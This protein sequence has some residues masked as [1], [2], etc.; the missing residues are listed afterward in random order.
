MLRLS[1]LLAEGLGLVDAARSTS[2]ERQEAKEAAERAMA[3]VPT[4]AP[5][6]RFD[7][8]I[9]RATA[10]IAERVNARCD[11]E[12][13]TKRAE[14]LANAHLPHIDDYVIAEYD[15]LNLYEQWEAIR[16]LKAEIRPELIEELKR[17]D[18]TVDEIKEWIEQTVGSVTRKQGFR[19]G[20]DAASRYES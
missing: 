11:R 20:L 19:T 5:R 15:H 4:G 3:E 16:E 9:E 2:A 17:N 14:S 12:K 7:A 8:A 1:S 10:P 18:L 13:R 6:D